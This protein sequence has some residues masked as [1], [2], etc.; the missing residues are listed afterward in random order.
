MHA[1]F[2][3][4]S[5]DN[6]H[7]HIEVRS[8]VVMEIESQLTT[9]CVSNSEKPALLQELS[10]AEARLEKLQRALQEADAELAYVRRRAQE[11]IE[12]AHKYAIENFARALL[13][14]KDNLEVSLCIKTDDIQALKE[15][16]E[17]TLKQLESAFDEN[18]VYEICPAVGEAFNQGRHYLAGEFSDGL[19]GKP[20]VGV[21]KKGYALGE[22]VLRPALVSVSA[23][24]ADK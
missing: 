13:S 24:K 3:P 7:M 10:E 11:D 17:L 15:G 20:I 22:R 9:E 5:L 8:S 6:R 2:S 18:N 16:V 1:I 14:F 19:N 12:H 21:Y 4:A 23:C